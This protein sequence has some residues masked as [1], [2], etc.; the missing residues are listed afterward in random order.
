MNRRGNLWDELISRVY[1]AAL[2]PGL[3]ASAIELATDVLEATR[4][5]IAV[6][7]LADREEFRPVLHRLDPALQERWFREFAHR[8]PW[9]Q[10]MT[11]LPCEF[12]AAGS[13]VV[14]PAEL[15]RTEIYHEFLRPDCVEDILGAWLG[16][17]PGGISHIIFYRDELFDR[18]QLR[19]LARLAPHLRRA[20]RTQER[21]VNLG[22]RAESLEAALDRLRAAVFVLQSDGRVLFANQKAETLARGTDGLV[23][24]HSRLRVTRADQVRAFEAAVQAAAAGAT[25]TTT[26][27]HESIP[28]SRRGRR[29]LNVLV[30]PVRPRDQVQWPL[31]PPE[32]R[33]KAAVLVTVTDPDDVASLPA[34]H[35]ARQFNLTPA[36]ARI[37]AALADRKSIEEYAEQAGITIGTARWTL[38]RVLEKTGC[39]RQSELVRLLATSPLG[40]VRT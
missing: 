15:R 18:R 28:I 38:K 17:G 23:L 21:L 7:S 9:T 33:S 22:E 1:D 8:D 19:L 14:P 5:K 30:T 29:P 34:E 2:D 11:Y 39:R 13:Q 10:S 6:T 27:A 12:V 40:L 20:V 24:R 32:L 3:W 35:L 4:A 31:L 26:V 36:E 25:G 37:A 16:D